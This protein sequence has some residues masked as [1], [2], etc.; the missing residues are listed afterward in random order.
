MSLAQ[1]DV[2]WRVKIILE[3]HSVSVFSSSFLQRERG[4][5]RAE[6]L[7]DQS[8]H[9]SVQI[10][11]EGGRVQAVEEV[12]APLKQTWYMCVNTVQTA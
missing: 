7:G 4:V 11:V 9:E 1:T 5:V 12:V 2:E 10:L 6:D 3:C 8:G